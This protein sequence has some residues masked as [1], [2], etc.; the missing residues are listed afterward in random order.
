MQVVYLIDDGI[1]LREDLNNRFAEDKIYRFK[2][3]KRENL[4]VALKDVPG[5]IIIN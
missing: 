4:E 1:K 2:T 5:A 3:V